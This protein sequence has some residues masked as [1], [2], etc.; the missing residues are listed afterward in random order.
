MFTPATVLLQAELVTAIVT[1][2]LTI[3]PDA[4]VVDAIALMNAGSTTG[5]FTDEINAASGLLLPQVQQSCVLVIDDTQLVGIVTAQDL[6]RLT[7]S[8]Q[9]LAEVAIAQV[10]SSPVRTLQAANFTDIF[11]PL[12]L[13]Q[14]YPIRHLPLVDAQGRVVGLLTH[15]S[16]RPLLRP[17]DILN[18]L[19]TAEVMNRA[20]VQA[21]PTATLAELTQLMSS[22]CVRA[23]VI[24]D[25]TESYVIPVGI[26]TERDIVRLLA[27]EL[28]FAIV[29]AQTIMSR[30][31]VSVVSDTSLGDVWQLMQQR[32][33]NQVIVKSDRGELLGI[34]TQSL[35]LNLLNPM[36]I[37]GLVERLVQERTRKIQEQ[38]AR[39]QLL[40]QI[41]TQIHGSLNLAEVLDTAVTAL[42][43]FLQ[44]DRLLVYQFQPDWSGIVVAESVTEKWQAL[45]EANITD[46]CFRHLAAG[47][48]RDGKT[49]AIDNIQTFGY[50]ACYLRM[51]E[52]HQVKAKLVVP[53]LVSGKLWGL[54]IGHQCADYR[55][56]QAAEL[57]L[58]G[59]ISLQLAIAIQQATAYQQLQIQNAILERIAKAEPLAEILQDLLQAIEMQ[60]VDAVCSIMLHNGDGK[61]YSVTTPQLSAAYLQQINGILI[62]EGFGSCGTA[63]F[64]RDTVIVSD[65]A[66]DPLW[67]NYREL[68]LAQGL[69]A[70]WSVPIIGSDDLILGVFGVYYRDN[71]VPQMPERE[72]VTQAANIASIAIERHLATQ[73]L[74]QLNQDLENRVAERTAALQA[75]EERWQLVLK[76][77][78]DGIWDWD[79]KTNKIFYSQ[80]WKQ[81]RGF[82]DDEIGDSPD[83]CLSR[84]H[85]DDYDRVMAA[86]NDHC[87][88]RTEFFETEYRTQC[89]DGS[90]MWV[91][92]R[93]QALRDESGEV[94]RMTGS[95][96]DIT[97][98]KLA[99][100]ELRESKRRYRTLAAAAP[101][102]IFRFDQPLNCVYVND[103]WSQMTGRPKES[104]LG[105]GWIEALHP[106]DREQRLA[107]WTENYAQATSGN[108]F[109]DHG[110]GRHLRPDGS[111]NW[112]YVQVA[113]EIDANGQ[114]IG[115]IG[116]LT[117][118]TA[119]KLAEQENQQL[120]ERLQFVLSA[121]PA[122]IFTCKPGGDYG[123]TFVSDNLYDVT[124][125][126]SAE[127]LAESSF[128]ID[129]VH[130]DD[131]PSLLAHAP[132]LISGQHTYEYRF[133][134]QQGHYIWIGGELR[135]V[136]NQQGT[137]I[138]WIGYFADISDRKLAELENQRLQERLQFLLSASPAV[139]FTCQPGGDYSLTFTSENIYNV[140]GYT[141]AEFMA[142]SNFWVERVH[143]EDLPRVMAEI[144]PL[145]EQ[146]LHIHEYRFLH[147]AGHYIWIRNE[148]RL[149]RD[150]QGNPLEIVGYTIDISDVYDELRLRKLAEQ[151]NQRLKER[152]Q[153]VLAANPAVIYTCRP[154]GDYGATFVSENIY[155]VT[156]YTS[157][158]LL[159]ESSFWIDRVHPEDLPR[160]LSEATQIL[161]L[162]Q[163]TCEYRFRHQQGHYIWIR[164]ELRVVRDQQGTPKEFVGYFV[165]ISD[166]KLAELAL[167][168][169]QRFIQQIADATPNMLYLCDLQTQRNVYVNREISVIL[170]YSP[171]AAQAMGT[172]LFQILLHPDDLSRLPAQL[173]R[174]KIAKDGEIIE[175]EYRMRHANGEWRWLYSWDAVFSRDAE[176]Q[177]QQ[178]IGTAQD[179]T[180]RKLA[181]QE[182][183]LL[184]E[185]LQF[186]LSSS[187]AV[188]FTVK[189]N[190]NEITF[191]SDNIRTM[192]GYTPD[193]FVLD[194]G[195]WTSH[196][197]PEDA[198]QIVAGMTQLYEQGQHIHE[199][200][201]LHQAGH[202]VWM[203]N[204]LRLIRDQ[205][206]N[207]IEIVGYG[208]D[209]SDRKRLEAAQNRL[210]AILEASTDFILIADL[211]GTAI[212]NNT[213]L[214]RFRGLD[215]LAVSQ[216]KPIDYHPQRGVELLEQQ[217]LPAAIA[218]GS[219]LGENILLDAQ[220]QEIPVSQL[221]LAHKS[222]QGEVEFFSTI[223]RDMRIHKEYEQRLERT[224]AELRR[225]TRLKDEFLANMSHELRTPLNAILG[226]SES[227][228]EMVFG[229]LNHQQHEAIATIERSGQHL[230]SLI[231][232]IL[233]LSKIEADKLELKVSS[234]SV[235]QLCKISLDFV[236]QQAFK[237]QIQLNF[238]LPT[239]QAEISADERRIQQVLI[240]LLSNAI[241]FTPNGGQVT[242]DVTVQNS[243]ELLDTHS[244]ILFSVTDTGIGIA[245]ADQ[246][247]LFQPFVQIDS[248]LN[249]KYEGTGLGLVLVKRIIELHGGNVSLR[250]ELGQGSCFTVS[251]P[252]NACQLQQT[253]TSSLPPSVDVEQNS[254]AIAPT[255]VITVP[256]T[257]HS[258]LILLAEDNEANINTISSYLEAKGY[259]MLVAKNGQ[260]AINL[261]QT[262]HPDL[263]VMDIQMPV[264][265][266][267][268][269]IER[270]RQDP[271]L[272]AIPIIALTAMAMIGDR[273]KC[274][275]SGASKYLA[276]PVKL[277][278]LTA[279]IHQLL[280][281]K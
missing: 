60:L 165:D 21:P 188:I 106:D 118:I 167:Q 147:K 74:Q 61:L 26:V 68:A 7:A 100:A 168:E 249:R 67:Q 103:R 6:V 264:V 217:A 78:N 273:E 120:Q 94:V 91:L 101:V 73:T 33:I 207:P 44:C 85:P 126:T 134:H 128:W 171:E 56:W 111:I 23:V 156:G 266:G 32:Q 193:D 113:P 18:L 200:R 255:Q 12:S 80:R 178:I 63:A 114:V 47:L 189:P 123:A 174:L 34:V 169:S 281:I 93:G 40:T 15:D 278:Q 227:L 22:H 182:N 270:I 70:C 260:E 97:Q 77:T 62:D 112:F 267:L 194:S 279:T 261:T 268:Q 83:D 231:N 42:R 184:K 149:I 119:R 107:E 127:F 205:Q 250:S 88:G 208:A 158:E 204:E 199:Y 31:V 48:Y 122:V 136:R 129:R 195:F 202:Y 98:S 203:R 137:P 272:A 191:V 274:L 213:A 226:M 72:T 252:Y 183:Q 173:S 245:P 259:R 102:A 155:N 196:V 65:I 179:I 5:N 1:D 181:E 37:S 159:A 130:P 237:K 277:K 154:E 197:H 55:H 269:A 82:T 192:L 3:A 35:L 142:E 139:I 239:I 253:S 280:T 89:Q 254:V 25:I 166:R 235:A 216:Q 223:M 39:E 228:I 243:S 46:P 20:V 105:R 146:G 69:K 256:T 121:S 232:D 190:S 265:D 92:D 79:L 24:V 16:L 236:K 124:G 75:S 230:L 99:E 251:L 152:L 276:K 59:E 151:E 8:G 43:G 215:D 71:R 19:K 229:S 95:E 116:T 135:V 176:G 241:K 242:L 219:W 161:A 275:A 224:N 160:V 238:T 52:Q 240:N 233:E 220:G 186:V 10:M 86:V 153:F 257:P 141:A 157:A 177:V 258:P 210:I 185:R 50:P 247:R 212:W 234:V 54:L 45:R 2:P 225:A 30:S 96:K 49:L 263:I 145:F 117:D 57:S 180:V 138:E 201:F 109:I 131:L 84:I 163:H 143:P 172:N 221:L 41:A 9:N 133:R 13:F 87:A 144:S 222:P 140:T 27:L 198:P 209:I 36:A 110:E 38:V 206:R 214:K 81:M 244:W 162:G 29:Q 108:H 17:F 76:G 246:A 115:Y 211:A 248:S 271:Q 170:G 4:S 175:Y 51:L 164:D 66:T 90:Y 14:H 148:L 53:I 132:L 58:L 125:Y 218:N 150:R 187:P 262:H 104:A 28:D 64:C 11:V